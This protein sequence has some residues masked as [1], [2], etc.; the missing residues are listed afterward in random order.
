MATRYCRKLIMRTKGMLISFLE[1]NFELKT[2]HIPK[3]DMR[4]FDGKDKIT[5]VLQMDKC[6]DLH[7]VQHTQKVHIASL[8]WEPNQFVWCQWLCSHKP[9]FTWSIFTK[10]MIAHYEDK[11]SN[12][13]FIEL[14]NL[15][16]KGSIVEHIEDFQKLNIRVIDIPKEHRIDVFIRT[17]KDNIIHDVHVWQLLMGLNFIPIVKGISLV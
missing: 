13:F 16:Q 14:I 5:W 4:K 10:E 7:D 3:I 12:T 11:N 1:T 2:N 15:K 17:L 9:L 8:Y 6:F